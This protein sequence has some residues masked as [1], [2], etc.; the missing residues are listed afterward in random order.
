MRVERWRTVALACL[1]GALVAAT[2]AFARASRAVFSAP[3]AEASMPWWARAVFV[4]APWLAAVLQLQ[5]T[6]EWVLHAAGL[7]GTAAALLAAGGGA[8]AWLLLAAAASNC[9]PA[10][11]GNRAGAAFLALPVATAA[12]VCVTS[13][14]CLARRGG[15]RLF[16]RVRARLQQQAG[17]EPAGTLNALLIPDAAACLSNNCAYP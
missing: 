8:L 11:A 1:G 14:C 6:V 10:W 9:M 3:S 15:A 5:L 4:A 17:H 16:A 13:G 2:L 12:L 7:L